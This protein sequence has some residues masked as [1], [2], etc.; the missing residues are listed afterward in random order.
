MSEKILNIAVIGGSGLAQKHAEGII[1]DPRANLYAI[2]DIDPE[3]ASA[4]AEKVGCTKVLTDYRDL[5]ND[6]ALDAV[7]LVTPDQ[8]HAEHTCAFLH[9]GKHVLCE[10]PMALSMEECE[11]MLKAEKEGTGRLMVGQ[12]GRCTPAF[13]LTKRLIAKGR[14]GE[15]MFVESEYA[16][17]YGKARGYKEWRL[18]PRR[19]IVIGGGCHAVDFL[20]W[21]AG[22][23]EEVYA[24][25]THKVL[26][27][28]PTDDTTIA[29][30]KFPGNIAGKVF[31]SSGCKRGYTMRS[32]F[33]GT[34]GTIICDNTS[35][36]I[37]IFEDNEDE[38]RKYTKAANIP[39]E[40]NNHNAFEEIKQFIDALI[41]GNPMP[42]SAV[43]GA[44]DVAVCAAIVEAAAKGHPI[45]VKYPEV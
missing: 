44:H 14:I 38:G 40:I 5:V 18:D 27:D 34:K 32:C 35:D 25:S 8:V 33:Y 26:T 4:L 28:W 1:K 9:A 29:I 21:I 41:T 30:M 15:L 11:Q 10:K 12:I 2:C 31:V 6:E 39:V 24:Y 42:I 22:D 45:K 37:Q 36:H 3:R 7:V 23:P 20:R 13:A 43:E 17:N 19:H 16:H